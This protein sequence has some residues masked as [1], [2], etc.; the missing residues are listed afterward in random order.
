MI[1]SMS[2]AKLISFI[3]RFM[4]PQKGLYSILILISFVWSLDVTIWP[5]LFA[6]VIRILT[7]HD[8]TRNTAWSFLKYPV[9]WALFLW[10]FVDL[11]CRLQGF[12]LTKLL[13]Q[14]ASDLRMS[15]FEHVQRHS[16]QYFNQNFSGAL[17]NKINDMATEV[18]QLLQQSITFYMPALGAYGLTVFFFLQIKP[19][20]ALIFILWVVLHYSC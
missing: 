12:L 9:F 20:F 18:P 10:I 1:F 14:I 4:R 15:L 11:G 5:Y 6:K 19:I 16:P 3:I 17:S 8:T 2:T 13:P 7:E